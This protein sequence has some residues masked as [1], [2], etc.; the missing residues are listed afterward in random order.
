M[1]MRAGALS[2]IV[3]ISLSVVGCVRREGRNTDCKWPGEIPVHSPDPRHLSGD[4][5][6]AE[7]LAIRYADIHYGLRTP[8]YVS[9]E[10]YDA[11]RDRCMG[12][13][14]EQ[15]AKQHSVPIGLVSDALGRNRAGIDFAVNLPFWLLY[16][17]AA[18]AA[19]RLIWR[20]YPPAEHGW[21]PGVTMALFLSLV[22]AALGTMLGE[23]WSWFAEAKRIGNDHMSYR[24]P[25]LWC[26]QHRTELFAGA[27]AAFWLAAVAAARR[28][29]SN[30]A[31]AAPTHSFS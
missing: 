27:V 5:E 29:R 8:N 9:G 30:G 22:I 4:A 1:T 31:M 7:D 23:M 20:K 19:A 17:L 21:M 24:V 11:A 26:V 14:F 25:R 10:V 18:I 16:C 2:A 6:F 13:L 3:L 15:I 12:S 28:V